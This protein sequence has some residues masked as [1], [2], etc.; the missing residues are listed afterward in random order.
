M[1]EKIVILRILITAVLLYM[2]MYGC[3]GYG[4]HLGYKKYKRPPFTV[5]LWCMLVSLFSISMF[6]A[7]LIKKN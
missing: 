3:I 2:T 1:N 7:H 5:V 4:I 6:I